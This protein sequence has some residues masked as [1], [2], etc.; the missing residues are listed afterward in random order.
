MDCVVI[1]KKDLDSFGKSLMKEVYSYLHDDY[2]L[3]YDITKK[4]RKDWD[5]YL[6]EKF[7]NFHKGNKFKFDCFYSKVLKYE[8][9]D[10]MNDEDLLKKIESEI[11]KL[12]IDLEIVDYVLDKLE[13][14]PDLTEDLYYEKRAFIN[15]YNT[16]HY[17]QSYLSG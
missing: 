17:H 3:T 11:K 4:L 1:F 5:K 14:E 13:I 6:V 9:L 10:K 16:Y 8:D 12:N 7:K 15:F 2:F